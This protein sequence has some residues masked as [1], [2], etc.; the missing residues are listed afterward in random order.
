MW[1]LPLPLQL[2]LV[3]NENFGSFQ[4]EKC[5]GPVHVTLDIAMVSKLS[6]QNWAPPFIWNAQKIQE[7]KSP[8]F[9]NKCVWN[10]RILSLR[11]IKI[12]CNSEL[13]NDCNY[14]QH[15]NESNNID[16]G[17]NDSMASDEKCV[18]TPCVVRYYR[19]LCSVRF[20]DYHFF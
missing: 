18:R 7:R 12:F 11:W 17:Y 2:I 3:V 9:Y 4:C 1:T 5:T 19:I 16:Y 14:S 13:C 10:V 20:N 6:L 8:I 15:S